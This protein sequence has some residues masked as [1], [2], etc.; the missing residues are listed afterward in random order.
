MPCK[1]N[2]I[3]RFSVT[4]WA[5][6]A[7]GLQAVVLTL[8]CGEFNLRWNWAGVCVTGSKSKISNLVL[9]CSSDSFISVFIL[10][11]VIRLGLFCLQFKV[12]QTHTHFK[13]KLVTSLCC[14]VTDRNNTGVQCLT[15]SARWHKAG[16]APGDGKLCC[17]LPV[18]G[19]EKD[20]VIWMWWDVLLFWVIKLVTYFIF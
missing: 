20:Q 19:G 5:T 10:K 18:K 12:C 14:H 9:N 2:G 13:N 16:R 4:A 7:A 17:L 11:T 8:K 15:L 1:A 3:K 6:Q